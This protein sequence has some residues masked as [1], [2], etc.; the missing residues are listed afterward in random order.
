[1]RSEKEKML[2]G[3]P[4]RAA[5]PELKADHQ[6]CQEL[7]HA[8]NMSPQDPG[9]RAE[10]LGLLLGRLGQR[11]TLQPPLY[12]DYGYNIRLGDRVFINYNCTLLDCAPLTIGE[13]TQIGPSVQIYTAVHPLV[14]AQRR[15]AVEWTRPVSIGANVWIGG[16]AVVL[17]GVTVGD[18]AV[19]GAGSV[20][21]RDVPEGAVVAGNPARLL[22]MQ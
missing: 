17:P 21:T 11:S 1:V 5:D 4:Y 3:E 22:R 6:R 19:I 10:L 16:A 15:A 20:V 7:L 14:P 2:A 12:C 13:K 8:F 18:D 9:L